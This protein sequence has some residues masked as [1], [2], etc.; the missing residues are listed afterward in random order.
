M[1]E[2]NKKFILLIILILVIFVSIIIT[3]R[4]IDSSFNSIDKESVK[5]DTIKGSLSDENIIGSGRVIINI[6]S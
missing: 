5:I 4:V 6:T 2:N 3:W 1:K